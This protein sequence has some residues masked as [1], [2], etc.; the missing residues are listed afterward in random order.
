MM[1]LHE[2]GLKDLAR[3]AS[4][5]GRIIEA[6]SDEADRICRVVV[7][8][9]EGLQNP[10]L[11]EATLQLWMADGFIASVSRDGGYL[12]IDGLI[13]QE[14]SSAMDLIHCVSEQIK[15]YTQSA[16]KV[17]AG[18]LPKLDVSVMAGSLQ[19]AQSAAL[20]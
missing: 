16:M 12:M 20:H 4:A 14:S 1:T 10:Q 11:R 9:R 2:Q 6:H 18:A 17:N 7:E 3:A 13:G 5:T 19:S 15:K 8:M